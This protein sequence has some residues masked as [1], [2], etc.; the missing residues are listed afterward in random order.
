MQINGK[1]VELWC[2]MKSKQPTDE[3]KVEQ[4]PKTSQ[5]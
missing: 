4:S 2:H 1:R 3:E 5:K